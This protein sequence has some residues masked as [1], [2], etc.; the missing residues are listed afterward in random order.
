MDRSLRSSEGFTLLELVIALALGA[1]ILLTA[2]NFLVNYVKYT[3]GFI[4]SEASLMGTSLAVF[5]EIADKISFTNKAVCRGGSE[6]AMDVPAVSFPGTCAN[7]SSCVQLRCDTI[8]TPGP[9]ANTP[10]T[11]SDDTVYTYWLSGTDLNKQVNS[12][13]PVIIATNVNTFSVSRVN[14]DNTADST[15]LNT[16]RL[17]LGFQ[18]ASGVGATGG[19]VK[20]YLDTTVI[21]RGKSLT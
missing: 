10:S 16:I 20:E 13:T 9:C 5:E 21:M 7:N 6:V 8:C 3:S 19:V 11:F 17:Q 14:K 2:S 12:G 18:A 1:V 15:Y 4:K